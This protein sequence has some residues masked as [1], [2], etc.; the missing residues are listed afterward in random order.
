MQV[1]HVLGNITADLD[2]DDFKI[3]V[4]LIGVIVVM[5]IGFLTWI[6]TRS[7]SKSA[8]VGSNPQQPLVISLGT[9]T[10]V[11]LIGALITKNQ[12]AFTLAATGMGAIAGAVTASWSHMQDQVKSNTKAITEVKNGLFFHRR[13]TDPVEPIVEEPTPEEA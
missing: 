6:I 12:D 11:A 4:V 2:G 3:V 8:E 1:A 5:V 9:L 13:S 7:M 10:F